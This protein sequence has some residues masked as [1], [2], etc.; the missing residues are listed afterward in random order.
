MK[1]PTRDKIDNITTCRL[2]LASK[3]GITGR[4]LL[5]Q[6][7]QHVVKATGDFLSQFEKKSDV[8][9]A[10]H[11]RLRRGAVALRLA[12]G[13]PSDLQL[14]PDPSS[15]TLPGQLQRKD[16]QLQWH[17][18]LA[19]TMRRPTRFGI[20]TRTNDM[21]AESKHSLPYSPTGPCPQLPRTFGAWAMD[22]DFLNSRQRLGQ[23]LNLLRFRVRL[24]E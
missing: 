11:L 9:C 23:T 6:L 10:G 20:W 15:Q 16:I 14:L 2:P 19:A 4:A 3:L 13:V 7:K 17:L 5:K 12:G 1:H 22:I 21:S 24:S 18:Q 8:Q